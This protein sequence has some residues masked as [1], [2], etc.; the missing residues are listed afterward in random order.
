MH[1][2]LEIYYPHL[3]RPCQSQTL[4]KLF[5]IGLDC[6]SRILLFQNKGQTLFKLTHRSHTEDDPQYKEK[7]P[8]IPPS[9]E[10]DTR[11]FRRRGFFTMQETPSAWPF[12]AP[13]KG[14]AKTCALFNPVLFSITNYFE[15]K[16]PRRYFFKIYTNSREPRKIKQVRS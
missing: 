14:F 3:I 8:H 13:T 10:A 15:T 4:L 16:I 12:K 1:D 9:K 11:Q 7:V 5:R 2:L 6:Q